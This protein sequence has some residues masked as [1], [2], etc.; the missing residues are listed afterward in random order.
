MKY[1]DG[2]FCDICVFGLVIYNFILYNDIC[3]EHSGDDSEIIFPFHTFFCP[4]YMYGQEHF[5]LEIYG[6]VTLFEPLYELI[7]QKLFTRCTNYSEQ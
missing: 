5:V 4:L 1:D 7:H 2:Y 6:A 3:L